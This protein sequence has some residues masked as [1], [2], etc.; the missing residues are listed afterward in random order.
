MSATTFSRSLYRALTRLYPRDF[1][2]EWGDELCTLF[3]DCLEAERARGGVWLWRLWIPTLGDLA[4]SAL[5]ERRA[6]RLCRAARIRP[7]PFDL[8]PGDPVG[9][10]AQ[11]LRYAWR[12]LRRSPGFTAVVLASLALGIGANA[13]I[14]SLVDGIVL[15]PYHWPEA[16]RLVAV[17][18]SFPKADPERRYI[19]A[20][21]AAEFADIRAGK[22][23]LASTFAFDLGNRNLSGG[24]RPERVFTA[25]LWGD[26]FATIG[27]RPHLGRG[28]SWEE[29]TG[30]GALAVLSHR[31]WKNRFAADSA[32]IGR[33]VQ[34]NGVPYTVTGVMPPELLVLGTDLWVPMGVDP[35]RLP[36]QARQFA[37]LGRLG[38]GATF[39][40]VNA[41]LKGLAAET[42]RQYVG[43]RPEYAGWSIEVAPWAEATTGEYRTLAMVLLG[44]VGL[45][46]L[47]AC[48]NIASLLLARSAM[49]AREIAV[50]R[51]LGAGTSRIARQLFTESL[52]LAAMG[53]VAGVA[54]ARL[55]IGPTISLL[56]SQ[57]LD[58]GIAPG[59]NGNVLLYALFSGVVAALVFGLAPAWRAV[60]GKQ[61]DVLAPDSG[62]HTTGRHGRY[63][64]HAFTVLE[65]A[66]A[67]ILLA[68]AGVLVRGFARLQAIDPG[69]DR[70]NVLTMRL[71]LPRE[72]YDR[73]RVAAFFEDLATRLE[74]VPGVTRAAAGTQYA[75]ANGFTAA[76]E[77]EGETRTTN[78]VREIDVSNVTERFFAT[79]GYT[80]LRGRGFSATDHETAPRVAVLNERA[81]RRFFGTGEVLGR[82]IRLGEGEDRQ[83]IEVV[84]IARDVRNR[85]LDTDPAPEVF[86]PVRQMDA[87]W[88]NQLFLLV[89]TAG[90]PELLLPSIRATIATMDA[91]QPVYAIR[92]IE[93]AFAASN[94]QRRAA[95]V[96]LSVLSGVALVL[97]AIGI[98]GLLSYLVSE[99]TQE[100][101]IRLALGA[102]ARDVVGMVVRQTAAVL[103]VGAVLGLAGALALGRG[104]TRLAYGVAP[105]DPVTLLMV[106]GLL[107]GVGLVASLLPAR[108]ATRVDPVVALRG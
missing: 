40:G 86:I 93:E 35:Y 69:F 48:A 94:A 25:F 55:L 96:L 89:K 88:N 16:D 42:E 58:A 8:R 18:V 81:A 11:D 9:T 62:R 20:L 66:L 47:I 44:A 1:R 36:R 61:S 65:V 15:R 30:G 3:G 75:P 41:E 19:E 13:L 80:M 51:A 59:I 92:T 24:D 6:A 45:V 103:G 33:A 34:V 97:A 82:R 54:L 98:Y 105:G 29:T 76:V 91:D 56:P 53:S 101:G 60:R 108:R 74:G 68:G 90:A 5:R 77:V 72:R 21:A 84:G 26:P 63:L 95:A 49:R 38:D 106:T 12:A 31:L 46:L 7:A 32:I 79:L 78:D 104:L 107:L 100:F 39:A 50:R 99:R 85:G 64:R 73:A 2:A 28:F 17:G 23:G 10:F 102:E 70:E 4:T 52:L 22:T 37:I 87:A 67:L 57:V 71:S 27:V 14:F 43:E 83:W